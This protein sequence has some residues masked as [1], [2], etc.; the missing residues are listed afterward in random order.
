MGIVPNR[1]KLINTPHGKGKNVFF[2][3]KLKVWRRGEVGM[4]GRWSG[5][6]FSGEQSIFFLAAPIHMWLLHLSSYISF[7]V[8]LYRKLDFNSGTTLRYGIA[9]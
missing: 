9:A 7:F 2:S 3:Q 1:V 5:N 4:Y 8:W 6:V